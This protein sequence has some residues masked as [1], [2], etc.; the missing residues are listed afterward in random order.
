MSNFSNPQFYHA[1]SLFETS[2]SLYMSFSKGFF[3][4][5]ILFI[6]HLLYFKVKF[7]IRFFFRVVTKPEFRECFF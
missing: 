7:V 1:L 2:L 3:N 6:R 5:M 4:Q